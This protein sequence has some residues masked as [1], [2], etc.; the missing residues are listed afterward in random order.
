MISDPLDRRKSP[1]WLVAAGVQLVTSSWSDQRMSIGSCVEVPS[2]FEPKQNTNR[3]TSDT[4]VKFCTVGTSDAP[5]S[6]VASTA[7]VSTPTE[8]SQ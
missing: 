3:L 8:A 2:V 7:R 1:A 5:D 4:S 6:V